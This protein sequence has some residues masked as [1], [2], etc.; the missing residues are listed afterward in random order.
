M[1]LKNVTGPVLKY[2]KCILARRAASSSPEP[3]ATPGAGPSSPAPPAAL[4]AVPLSPPPSGA[5]LSLRRKL[6]LLERM[7]DALT[8]LVWCLTTR[9][10]P[11]SE[12]YV[13]PDVTPEVPERGFGS[14]DPCIVVPIIRHV[15]I[16]G[17]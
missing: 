3:P 15:W 14:S 8:E 17:F 11:P 12:T 1:G 5:D 7:V 10:E 13:I 4:G 6:D 2:Q 16:K 9:Y